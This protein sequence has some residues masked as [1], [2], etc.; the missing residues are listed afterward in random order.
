[1]RFVSSGSEGFKNN[2]DLDDIDVTFRGRGGMLVEHLH[3][4][5]DYV[6]QFDIVVIDIASNDLANGGCPLKLAS[7]VVSFTEELLRHL[8]VKFVIVFQVISRS[9]DGRYPLPLDFD[10]Q[11]YIYNGH[12]RRLMDLTSLPLRTWRVTGFS[13]NVHSYLA[14]DGV[15]LSESRRTHSHSAMYKYVSALRASVVFANRQVLLR[16]V[17]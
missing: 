11:A 17:K 14:R 8:T 10:E 2:L 3:R 9:Q 16:S 15:H 7:Q 12:L 13:K 5:L 6:A 4:H 1:M